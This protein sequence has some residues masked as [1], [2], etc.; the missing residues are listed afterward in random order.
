[1]NLSGSN[2]SIPIPEE[3]YFRQKVDHFGEMQ[4]VNGTWFNQYFL[5]VDDYYKPGGPVFLFIGGE[6]A[7]KTVEMQRGLPLELAQQYNG[8]LLHLEH[9]FYGSEVNGRSVPTAD[10]NLPSLSLCTS[11]QAIEDLAYFVQ[12]FPSQYR[13]YNLTR[14]TKWISI[15]GSYP[16]A[17]SAW[18]RQKYPNL[19][20]AAHASSAP[21]LALENFWRYSYAVGEAFDYFSGSKSCMNGW[22]RAIQAMD[23]KMAD[24]NTYQNML[25]FQSNFFSEPLSQLM[26]P[27]DFASQVSMMIAT[28]AQY[29]P[30]Y[31]TFTLPNGNKTRML[32]AL[33]DGKLFPAFTNRNATST[34]LL[35]SLQN[36]TKAYYASIETSARKRR[37][38]G[39]VAGSWHF[40]W[41][42]ICNEFGYWQ[43]AQPL[44]D[45]IQLLQ[46]YSVYSQE[47]TVDYFRL[48][49]QTMKYPSHPK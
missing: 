29:G 6:A 38:D 45:P 10:V 16:G 3:H 39:Q 28:T 37:R 27:A 1:M 34:I 41:Y 4:G 26:Y 47:I 5:L 24:I 30:N 23:Q 7:I 17:L 2:V 9:R 44:D 32:N 40:W 15:G 31:Q 13:K 48:V 43:V 20:Y 33:C 22:T 35:S 46:S 49:C 19:I 42:Q 36:L 14:E 25:S 21:V 11:Q 18:L 12:S 8:L